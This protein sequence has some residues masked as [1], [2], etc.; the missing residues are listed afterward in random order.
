[1]SARFR[2]DERRI[3]P[4]LLEPFAQNQP[5][6][7]PTTST[8]RA[9]GARSASRTASWTTSGVAAAATRVTSRP[10]VLATM[11][12]TRSDRRHGYQHA[13]LPGAQRATADGL[14]EDDVGHRRDG[15]GGRHAQR[16]E[17]PT[18][19]VGPVLV[20]QHVDRP[21][22]QVDAVADEA[23]PPQGRDAQHTGD[24]APIRVRRR[25]R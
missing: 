23:E 3:G 19:Q 11:A 8:R 9:P 18:T 17:P 7:L 2:T 4:K 1:M 13:H 21:V 16:D 12:P 15:E 24:R 6:E 10:P 14:L 25:P 5:T 22:P 20:E